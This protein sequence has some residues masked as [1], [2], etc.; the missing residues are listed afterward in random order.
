MTAAPIRNVAQASNYYSEV[1]DYY[2]QKDSAATE[3][4]GDLAAD[5]GLAGGVDQGDFELVL[6]GYTPDGVQLGR[7]KA[8][9]GKVQW[10][11]RPGSDLT[12]SAP[13]T[14]SCVA[15]VGNGD[16]VRES[17]RVAVFATLS[18]LQ[19]KTTNRRGENTGKFLAATFE[20]ET[21]RDQGAQLHTHCIIANLTKDAAGRWGSLESREFFSRQSEAGQIYQQE[22][23]RQLLQRGFD[24]ERV[25]NEK[26]E[27]WHV[28]IRGVP[29]ELVDQ[30]SSRKRE[31]D[32]ALEARGIDPR[33]A[34]REARAAANRATRRDK[35]RI[36][37]EQ[38]HKLWE[39]QA[40]DSLAALAHVSERAREVRLDPRHV[41]RMS[42]RDMQ[43]A[44]AQV[45]VTRSREILSERSSRFSLIDLT[46]RAI[47][48]AIGANVSRED[49]HNEINRQVRDG[50]LVK[51]HGHQ[52]DAGQLTTREALKL[53]RALLAIEREGRGQV[54][55]LSSDMTARKAIAMTAAKSEWGWTE[56]QRQAAFGI[57]TSRNRVQGLQGYAGTAKTTSVIR[58]VVSEAKARGINVVGLAPTHSAVQTLQDGGDIAD[59]RTVASHIH[60]QAHATGSAAQIELWV[61]DESS[62]LSVKDMLALQRQAERLGA[63]VLLVGDTKQLD[64]VGAGRAFDQA[65][66][67]GMQ[68]HK[69]TEIVRQTSNILRDGVYDAIRGDAV[70]ALEK[71]NRS[72]AVIE[73]GS[74][75]ERQRALVLDYMAQGLEERSAT[76]II[77]PS[78]EGRATLNAMVRTSRIMAGELEQG[79]QKVNTL[80]RV[81]MTSAEKKSAASYQRGQVV[82]F[83][84]DRRRERLAA[85]VH[86]QVRCVDLKAGRVELVARS[87]ESRSFR[88]AN[89]SADQVT[90][91]HREQIDLARGDR[92]LFTACDD[93][94]RVKNGTFATV[95]GVDATIGQLSLR[96]DTGRIFAVEASRDLPLRHGYAATAHAAQGMTVKRVFA[97]LESHRVNLVTQKSFYV[98][99]SRAKDTVRVYTDDRARLAA[100]ISRRE[101][102][103]TTALGPYLSAPANGQG[104][105]CLAVAALG[106]V[107]NLDSIPLATK[108]A[109]GA[110][111][112][113]EGLEAIDLVTP[114]FK[115]A[116]SAIDVDRGRELSP[117]AKKGHSRE[118]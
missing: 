115:A 92:V 16:S 29:L 114:R 8:Q 71:V 2:S 113:D 90:V 96:D 37:R 12:F 39:V 64:S 85:G 63:R 112:I 35:K 33:S 30:H 98:S 55:S 109:A 87:G 47:Q 56:G 74:T 60:S 88:P 24:V 13:K 77:D 11:H 75:A 108:P 52:R 10:T 53:E 44:T 117:R 72:G 34:S 31:I 80:E 9:D 26:G 99:M 4:F 51:V 91:A 58:L 89:V 83:G 86:Y 65:Q 21:N 94:L 61:V 107:R 38:L 41:A 49:L 79:G 82:T 45:V 118:I 5:Y 68:T 102:A 70:K 36:S 62:L 43:A 116:V 28:E 17:H 7:Y 32:A 95:L 40:G 59:A 25:K 46:K 69:I 73:A 78:R 104:R 18:Y 6:Q 27:G 3:W 76:L 110:E 54:P 101:G 81:D 105:A 66:L 23:A 15:L 111:V 103:N 100:A 106:A 93:A 20:H 67:A 19:D 50:E 48:E 22:L 97:H 57:L 1:D 42:D 14:A 84:R